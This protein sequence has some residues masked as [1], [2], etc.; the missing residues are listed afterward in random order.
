MIFSSGRGGEFTSG[1]TPTPTSDQ[2]LGILDVALQPTR[3]RTGAVDGF[4]VVVN[5][6]ANEPLRNRPTG[7]LGA[8][9]T[10]AS[11]TYRLR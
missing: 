6:L 3:S 8:D 10:L 11:K 5:T 9:T 1:D 2:G 4:T 7:V